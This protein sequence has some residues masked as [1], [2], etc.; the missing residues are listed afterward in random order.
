MSVLAECEAF[1]PYSLQHGLL[2]NLAT[3]PQSSALL[4]WARDSLTLS[5]SATH[6]GFVFEGSARLSCNAGEF[7]LG[8]GMYFALPGEGTL[9]GKGLGIVASRLEQRGLFQLGG[10]VEEKGRLRYIDGCSDT[11][12]LPPVVRGDPCLNLLFVPPGTDQTEHTHP[13]L[14]MGLILSGSGRCV[15]PRGETAL[16][17]GHAFVIPRGARH[18]FH[19]EDE[20]LRIIAYHPDSDFGPTDDNHPMLNRTYVDGTAVN[21]PGPQRNP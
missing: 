18:S 11:L 17:P 12:L 14:R 7:T 10:P 13:S 5:P 16:V 4:V 2:C 15:T 20:A 8:E 6:L 9:E 3:D 19:T 1:L 21:N